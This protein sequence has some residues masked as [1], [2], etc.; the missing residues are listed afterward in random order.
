[1]FTKTLVLG[2]CAF[3]TFTHRVK[4]LLCVCEKCP[5]MHIEQ[6]SP[7]CHFFQSLWS[8]NSFSFAMTKND[9]HKR[10]ELHFISCWKCVLLQFEKLETQFKETPI[11]ILLYIVT[12]IEKNSTDE[13]LD[14]NTRK[15]GVFFLYIPHKLAEKVRFRTFTY[16][17]SFAAVY[18]VM[19][20]EHS[21]VGAVKSLKSSKC[22]TFEE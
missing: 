6:R 9:Y 22:G 21:G 8:H 2:R 16:I 12:V 15:E 3:M 19:E 11:F 7:K 10:L 5:I 4:N 18:S 13:N 1:M 17:L 14:N 20:D